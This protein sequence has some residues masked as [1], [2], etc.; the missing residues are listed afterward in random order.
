MSWKGKGEPADTYAV[1]CLFALVVPTANAA[2]GRNWLPTL[3][4]ALAACLL[5]GVEKD[6]QLPPWIR[7]LRIGAAALLAASF[8]E[9]THPCWPD[10]GAEYIVPLLLLALAVYAVG[11]GNEEAFRGSNV[12]RF[13]VYFLLSLLLLSG[14]DSIRWGRLEPKAEYPDPELAAVLLLPLLI[15][16]KQG[17]KDLPLLPIVLTVAL[18]T[19]GTKERDLYRFSQG[20]SIDGIAEHLE[21]LTACVMTAGYYALLVLLLD[22]AAAEQ[23]QLSGHKS[24][25]FLPILGVGI[26]AAY[27]VMPKNI[28]GI[29]ILSELIL[30]GLV[31]L[32]WQS[33]K[34]LKKVKKGVDK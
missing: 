28:W 20:L 8:L 30:W 5:W 26:Y 24:V 16:K 3:I 33:G 13:G 32:I 29:L 12:L 23:T 2:V 22:V 19:A 10:R 27:L 1:F 7:A 18:V 34:F 25:W 17:K 9:R 21:S 6:V 14:I 15:R 31:P 11:R 4:V